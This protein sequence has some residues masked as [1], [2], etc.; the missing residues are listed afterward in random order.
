MAFWLAMAPAAEAAQ[1]YPNPWRSGRDSSI[2]VTFA[3]FSG[4]AEIKIY[5]I[6]A[7]HVKTIQTSGSS[8]AWDLTNEAGERIASGVYLAAVRSAEGKS[9]LKLAVIR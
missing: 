6:A 3:G 7:E 1:A 9:V 2:P 4:P 8:A 5:T